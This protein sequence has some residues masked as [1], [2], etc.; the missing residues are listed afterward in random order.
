MWRCRVEAST[1]CDSVLLSPEPWLSARGGVISCGLTVF[2]TPKEEALFSSRF[3][4]DAGQCRLL[5]HFYSERM[6]QAEVAAVEILKQVT[7][8][9][10][11]IR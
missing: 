2:D 9:R 3:N 1:P 10:Q 6:G 4:A 7:L 5:S 11:I 8:W